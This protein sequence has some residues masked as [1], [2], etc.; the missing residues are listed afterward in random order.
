[1]KKTAFIVLVL[2]V[3]IAGYFY[4]NKPQRVQF[5]EVTNLHLVRISDDA[6]ELRGELVFHNPNKMRSQLG[7]VKFDVKLNDAPIGNID[8]SFA[9]AIKANEDFH[10]VFQIRFALDSAM[11]QSELPGDIPVIISGSAGSDV[12]FANYTFPVDYSGIVKNTIQ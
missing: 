6:A 9:T 4:F 10:F 1:V 5:R 11:A 12:L 2:L 7:R 8:E 3:F